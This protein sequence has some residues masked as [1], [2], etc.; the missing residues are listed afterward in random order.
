MPHTRRFVSAALLAS[1][2][3]APSVALAQACDPDG[4]FAPQVEYGTGTR[5]FSIAIGDL[6]GDGVADLAV[7]NFTSEDVSVLL[8]NGDGTF[9]P[10]VR[11]DGGRLPRSVA[12]GDLDGDGD[13]DLAVA[14]QISDGIRIL[15]NSGDGTLVPGRLLSTEENPF[16]VAIADLDGDGD[17]DLAA[18]SYTM[19]S[20]SVLLNDG[21]GGFAP[22]LVY[23]VGDD[24][25]SL[26]IGDLDNDGDA[27]LVTANSRALS[28]G[29]A[30]DASVLLNNGDGTLAPEVRYATGNRT[31]SVA[32]GDLDGD[33]YP[34]LAVANFQTDNVGVLRNNGNGTFGRPAFYNVG[35]EPFSV[36]I[37]D[38][39]GDGDLD[40][41]TANT[42]RDS[43]V[44]SVL[45][46]SGDGT[47]APQAFYGV[48]SEPFFV[49]IGDLDGDSDADMAVANFQN[50]T[51]GVLLNRCDCRVD[52]DG[53]GELS[54]TDYLA[55]QIAFMAGDPAADFDGDGR[56]N[57][58]DFLFFQNEFL[59]GCP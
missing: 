36:A 55:F 33:G 15:V 26:A 10:E 3:V 53:N 51:I 24:P 21:D 45:A 58:F 27:D 43:E 7:T 49:A 48:G 9:A 42:D 19:A 31:S 1:L 40:L 32:V 20:V 11:Y 59:A 39:D 41:A 52:F 23:S 56:L 16:S 34:D 37:G 14:F 38:L 8:N 29:G 6:N 25:Q 30:S 22:Q 18:T 47:F 13:N 35:D 2:A 28:G 50:S 44:I 54:L 4:I 5:T 46:N 17:A 57:V 12:I